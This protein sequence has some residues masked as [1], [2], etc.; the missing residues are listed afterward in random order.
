MTE[1]QIN[2]EYLYLTWQVLS[3]LQVRVFVC[4]CVCSV[5]VKNTTKFEHSCVQDRAHS[6]RGFRKEAA[7]YSGGFSCVVVG[8]SLPAVSR[9]LM[10][11]LLVV[12]LWYYQLRLLLKHTTH[13]Q[14]AGSLQEA[15]SHDRSVLRGRDSVAHHWSHHDQ[16]KEVRKKSTLVFVFFCLFLH[17]II[18]NKSVFVLYNTIPHRGSINHQS[19]TD[20]EKKLFFLVVSLVFFCLFM[21]F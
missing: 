1:G 16:Q 15:V 5:A 11:L 7:D 12:S 13:R 21:G 19:S 20:K 18:K 2:R 17:F 4:V 8:L 9:A 6:L 14:E 10:Q 3:L